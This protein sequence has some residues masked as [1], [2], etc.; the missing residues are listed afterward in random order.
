MNLTSA[1]DRNKLGRNRVIL[2]VELNRFANR[3]QPR[4]RV[5]SAVGFSACVLAQSQSHLPWCDNRIHH[6]IA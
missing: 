1:T 4:F 2:V 5:H 3:I 6:A